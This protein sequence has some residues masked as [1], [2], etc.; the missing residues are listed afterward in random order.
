MSPQPAVPA[1]RPQPQARAAYRA[2][3]TLATRWADN[4]VYCVKS[5]T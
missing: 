5:T 4:D 1:A 3:R 2:F